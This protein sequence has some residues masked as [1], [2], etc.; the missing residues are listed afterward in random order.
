MVH[1][2]PKSALVAHSRKKI[3]SHDED[4]I[5]A[6]DTMGVRR[7]G[8]QI[9][10]S[11]RTL[12]SIIVYINR[13]CVIR[14][15]PRASQDTAAAFGQAA[16]RVFARKYTTRTARTHFS[17]NTA[18]SRLFGLSLHWVTCALLAAP[19]SAA[20]GVD[21][22]GQAHN[23]ITNADIFMIHSKSL[24]VLCARSFT[25]RDAG[26]AQSFILVPELRESACRHRYILRSLLVK[27]PQ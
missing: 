6:C 4:I 16:L 20:F 24:P 5:D 8:S 2:A 10:K 26:A 21:G 19:L 9:G 14:R 25:P 27:R 18:R 13:F 3:K 23:V 22:N 1:A 12:L 7:A 11:H 15:A 17:T